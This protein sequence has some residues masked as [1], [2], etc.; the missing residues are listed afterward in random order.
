MRG[1]WGLSGVGSVGD[2]GDL[3][4]SAS[5]GEG[6]R[7]ADR[8]LGAGERDLAGL[9]CRGCVAPPRPRAVLGKR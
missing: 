8:V 6:V 1:L 4:G 5:R 9:G 3:G 7:A 2:W